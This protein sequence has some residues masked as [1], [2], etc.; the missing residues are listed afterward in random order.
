[1]YLSR[2][3]CKIIVFGIFA[4]KFPKTSRLR[5]IPAGWHWPSGGGR[6]R[7]HHLFYDFR[8]WQPLL[9]F[10]L[11][12]HPFDFSFP[13]SQRCPQSVLSLAL[14]VLAFYGLCSMYP[15]RSWNLLG[16]DPT[17]NLT[18]IIQQRTNA[19]LNTD[20]LCASIPT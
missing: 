3:P 6:L 1:M 10:G 8:V 13:T 11:P 9:N 2:P 12:C 7:G 20:K 4:A 5:S 15:V 17:L 18:L 19:N 14:I 16:F